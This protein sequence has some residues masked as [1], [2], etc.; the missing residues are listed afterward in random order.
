MTG[1]TAAPETEETD[2]T[3]Y[4]WIQDLGRNTYSVTGELLDT[5]CGQVWEFK[6]LESLHFGDLPT[7]RETEGRDERNARKERKGRNDG[8]KE[9]ERMVR[10]RV[11]KMEGK[12]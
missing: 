9:K 4:L 11:E 5:R 8:G 2:G 7:R 10:R 6:A 12:K 1:Q 3:V